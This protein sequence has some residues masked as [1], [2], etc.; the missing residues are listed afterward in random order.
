MYNEYVCDV[1]RCI[2]SWIAKGTNLLWEH[3]LRQSNV[4]YIVYRNDIE[5]R[6]E[7]GHAVYD[8]ENKRSQ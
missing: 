2:Y 5:P 3:H 8:G 6:G 7:R 4:I 1:F